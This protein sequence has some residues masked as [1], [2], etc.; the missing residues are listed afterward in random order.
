MFQIFRIRLLSCDLDP[1]QGKKSPIRILTKRHGSETL[2]KISEIESGL[3]PPR[4]KFLLTFLIRQGYFW[5]LQIW[6]T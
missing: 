3:Y 6:L 5:L 1:E 4:K 2:L